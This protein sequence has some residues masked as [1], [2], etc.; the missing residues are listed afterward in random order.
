MIA[1]RIDFIAGRFHATPWQRAANDGDVEWP[2]APW[3]IM[4]ALAAGWFRDPVCD[5]DTMIRLLDRL[6]EPPRFLLPPATVGHTRHYMP[7]GESKSLKPVT[8]LTLDSFV[9]MDAP[10]RTCAWVLWD[11][12]DLDAD[13][14]RVL[15]ALLVQVPYLGRAE[16]WCRI[17]LDHSV[18][19][20]QML[21]NVDLASRGQTNGPVVQRLGPGASLRGAGLWHALVETTAEMRKSRRRQPQGTV[22]LDY[23]FPPNFGFAP[24]L[25][26]QPSHDRPQTAR[27]ERFLLE[28]IEPRGVR[29]PVSDT[30]RVASLMRSA[31]L[32][33]SSR[34][35]SETAASPLFSGRDEGGAASGHAHAYFL[36]R[37]LDDDGRID[38][39]DVRLPVGGPPGEITALR[40]IMHLWDRDGQHAVRHAVTSLGEA[41][42]ESA[43]AWRSSTPFIAPRHPKKP[44]LREGP[45]ALRSWVAEQVALELRNHRVTAEVEIHVWPA[46][47]AILLHRGGRHTRFDVFTQS[48]KRDSERRQAFGV[49]LVFAKP[50]DGPIAIGSEA[51]YGLG[52]FRP[53]QLP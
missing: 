26:T 23:A 36:P 4:R 7:Q 53:V 28:T 52:Q 15:A 9:R 29:P 41:Q 33:A 24:R 35:H 46:R 6:S 18:P 8:A 45:E 11:N 42:L 39:I 34:V 51:H 44:V 49:D 32:R 38:H 47:P 22:L 50:Q 20:S 16:S 27:T 3:R 37:D 19:N 5:R 43:T 13:S 2:P 48:H 25:W 1:L 30:V 31:A 10:E 40:S 21:W 17:D 12:I 14:E